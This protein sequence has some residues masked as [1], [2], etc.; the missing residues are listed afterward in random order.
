MNMHGI[1]HLDHR[2]VATSTAGCSPLWAEAKAEHAVSCTTTLRQGPFAPPE[3]PG[4]NATMNPSDSQTSPATVIYSRGQ[5]GAPLQVSHSAGSL[6]FLVDLSIPA[7]RSHPGGFDR[8]VCSLLRGRYWLHPF[9]RAGHPQLLNEA[10]TGS[11]S[12]RLA[13]SPSEASHHGLLRRAH[14]RLHVE[15]AIYMF[16]SF[17]LKRPSRLN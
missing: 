15:R 8:C 1:L 10:E 5:F 11:L 13:P 14:G 4:F 16:S 3:L 12:L 6:R 9:W 2:P 17:Q 7:V